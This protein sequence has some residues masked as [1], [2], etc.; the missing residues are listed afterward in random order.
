MIFVHLAIAFLI[1][2]LKMKN[3]FVEPLN[4]VTKFPSIFRMAFP[5][6]MSFIF[7]KNNFYYAIS[8]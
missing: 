2:K 1:E 8:N 5:N 4:T 7:G 3:Y 6:Y